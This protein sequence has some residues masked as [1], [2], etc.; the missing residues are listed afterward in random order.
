MVTLCDRQ[1]DGSS[2]IVL[3]Q[4]RGFRGKKRI[5]RSTIDLDKVLKRGGDF[6]LRSIVIDSVLM[7]RAHNLSNIFVYR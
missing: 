7:I 1:I 4:D 3:N 6:Q 2:G 5:N